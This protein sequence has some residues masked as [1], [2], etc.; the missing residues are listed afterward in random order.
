MSTEMAAEE[1]LELYPA[2]LREIIR[3]F[4]EA[5]PQ[6]R[7]DY[8]LDFAESMPDLP[9]HLLAQRDQM[10]QVHECQTPV[11]IHAELTDGHLRLYFDVPRES[12]TVRG[13]AAI[14]AEGLNG[15]TPDQ[16]WAIPDELYR[17]LGLHEAISPLRLRGLHALMGYVKRQVVHLA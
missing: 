15:A 1:G 12:P 2:R 9:E 5:S 7:V 17:V 13:Y 4:R 8:L 10:E 11:F 16:V 3:E 6:E 14:V